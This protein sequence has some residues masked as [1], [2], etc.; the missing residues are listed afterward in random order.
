MKNQ[1]ESE[2]DFVEENSLF[3]LFTKG[4]FQKFAEH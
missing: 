2:N 4:D 1:K 3:E